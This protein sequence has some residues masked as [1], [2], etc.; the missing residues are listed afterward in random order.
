MEVR[1][2]RIGDNTVNLGLR[3]IDS[4]L[5]GRKI[6]PVFNFIEL[7]CPVRIRRLHK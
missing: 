7:R 6:V 4:S 5:K 2:F 1:C 3:L